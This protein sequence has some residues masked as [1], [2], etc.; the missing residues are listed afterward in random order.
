[1]LTSISRKITKRNIERKMSKHSMEGMLLIENLYR[2]SKK[3][4]DFVEF[5][6]SG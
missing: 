1:M 4:S 3:R 5:G 2:F 6:K